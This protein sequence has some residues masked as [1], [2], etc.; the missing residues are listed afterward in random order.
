MTLYH[1]RR[2]IQNSLAVYSFLYFV[3]FRRRLISEFPNGE[4]ASPFESDD[5]TF[6]IMQNLPA[7]QTS[8]RTWEIDCSRCPPLT[9]E[10]VEIMFG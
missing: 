9:R 3:P 4:R 10:Y 6:T 1:N 7:H 2:R 5:F 8:A